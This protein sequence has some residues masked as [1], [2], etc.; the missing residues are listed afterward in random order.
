MGGTERLVH[1]VVGSR[2]GTSFEHEKF[3]N[4]VL[5]FFVQHSM[6]DPSRIAPIIDFIHEQK[7]VGEGQERGSPPQPS[8]TMKGRTPASL[9]RQVDAWHRTLPVTK[10]RFVDWPPPEIIPLEFVEGSAASGNRR[11][12]TTTELL[13]TKALVEEGRM[14]CHCVA[15]YAR[16]CAHSG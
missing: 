4:T 10:Q 13:T 2:L 1:A 9:L 7:F 12:W 5:Q 6:L 3:W 11:S 15:S 16:S 14:M 8:F